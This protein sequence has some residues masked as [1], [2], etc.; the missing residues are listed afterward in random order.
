[1]ILIK[2]YFQKQTWMDF[3]KGQV[4]IRRVSVAKILFIR[5]TYVDTI[6]DE[7]TSD[8]HEVSFILYVGTPWTSGELRPKAYYVLRYC[9]KTMDK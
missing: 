1:M 4:K 9:Y 2:S 7:K 3:A 6:L 8:S 5:C